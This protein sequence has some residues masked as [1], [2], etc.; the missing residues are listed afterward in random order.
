MGCAMGRVCPP[1][2]LDNIFTAQFEH[3][4]GQLHLKVRSALIAAFRIR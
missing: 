2:A 3:V 4:K 1:P